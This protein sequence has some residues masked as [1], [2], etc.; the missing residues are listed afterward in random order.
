MVYLH[1]NGRRKFNTSRLR[2]EEKA[3]KRKQ[4]PTLKFI[5]AIPDV[6][7]IKMSKLFALAQRKY[8]S[9]GLR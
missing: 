2:F 4:N 6:H 7:G 9:R 3:A 5:Q 8:E 1:S